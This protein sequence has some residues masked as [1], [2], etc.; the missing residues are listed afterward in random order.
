MTC[1]V[2]LVDKDTV[3]MG[4]DS[5][6]VGGGYQLNIRNDQKVFMNGAFLMGFTTSFRMGQLLRY[7]FT[8]PKIAEDQ[9]LYE[10][11]VTDWIDG[12]R[13]CLKDGGFA[14]EKDSVEEGGT[15]LVGYKGRLFTIYEDYQVG[16]NTCGYSSV[17]CGEDLAMGSLFTSSDIKLKPED[18]VRMALKAAATFSAGVSAPFVVKSMSR[19]GQHKDFDISGMD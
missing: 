1:I 5:A 6:G 9:D 15:F 17:G 19:D 3:Y 4:G 7:S 8:P 13:K 14:S 2:G 16:E 11:M 10:Y 12:V 18:R